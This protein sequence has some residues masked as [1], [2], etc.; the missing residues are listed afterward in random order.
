MHE[1]EQT[2]RSPGATPYKCHVF[3]CINDRAGARKSCADGGSKDLAADLKAAAKARFAPGEVRVSKSLCLGL[4]DF[5]PNVVL[6]P[7]RT[8]FQAVTPDDIDRI[9]DE[10]ARA[11]GRQR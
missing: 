9:L 8:W 2:D 10:V 4:C 11:I 3:V 7:Q 6:Y 1:R 5:G